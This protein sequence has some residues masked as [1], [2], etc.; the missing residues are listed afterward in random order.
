MPP[1]NLLSALRGELSPRTKYSLLLKKYGPPTS[2]D[3][4]DAF[5][6]AT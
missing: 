4:D 1:H 3:E 6:A 5:G 2:A